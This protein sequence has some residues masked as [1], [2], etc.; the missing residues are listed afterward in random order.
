[1]ILTLR[2]LKQED[3]EIYASLCYIESETSMGYIDLVSNKT[4][5]HA[6]LEVSGLF[7]Y[8]VHCS[9]LSDLTSMPATLSFKESNINLSLQF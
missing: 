1:M 7:L 3:L 2:R 4:K 9:S 5:G 8:W 6:I